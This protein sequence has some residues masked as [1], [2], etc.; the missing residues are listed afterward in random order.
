MTGFLL[1]TSVISHLASGRRPVSATVRGWFDRNAEALSL[2]TVALA[3]LAQGI[4]KLRRLE[5]T[6]RAD[7]LRGWLDALSA[8]FSSRVLVFDEAAAR[9]FGEMADAAKSSG[10][11]PGFADLAIAAIAS[12]RGLTVTTCNLRH[13]EPLG[14]AAVDP[15]EASDNQPYA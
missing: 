12:A 3:E 9:V 5:A 13:F 1:D 11:H 2:S 10:R 15:F 8:T 14:A 6:S 7:A 4:A